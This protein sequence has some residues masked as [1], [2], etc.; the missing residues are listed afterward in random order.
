MKVMWMGINGTAKRGWYEIPKHMEGMIC[1]SN[2]NEVP[3]PT[4]KS[5]IQSSKHIEV[6]LTQPIYHLAKDSKL[7]LVK[8]LLVV[9]HTHQKHF[10]PKYGHK[11]HHKKSHNELLRPPH[12]ASPSWTRSMECNWK[13]KQ[14]QRACQLLWSV[15]VY[16]SNLVASYP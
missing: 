2:W 5:L 9:S 16:L 15:L 8:L 1:H 14:L 12:L 7:H 3:I 4:T 6:L 13:F 11:L 10:C